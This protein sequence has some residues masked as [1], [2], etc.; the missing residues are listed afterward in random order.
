MAVS[1]PS[2]TINMGPGSWPIMRCRSR[3]RHIGQ[4]YMLVMLNQGKTRGQMLTRPKGIN[5]N[6]GSLTV[7]L[8]VRQIGS[9][10]LVRGDH[11]HVQ[12]MSSANK[13]RSVHEQGNRE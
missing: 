5:M 13:G 3:G 7:W 4:G 2:C 12:P 1:L 10:S 8:M 6:K 11:M 9:Q